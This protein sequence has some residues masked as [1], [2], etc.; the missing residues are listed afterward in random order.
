MMSI[1]NVYRRRL[2]PHLINFSM[3]RM[4]NAGERRG[5][6]KKAAGVVLEIGCGSGLNVPLYTNVTKLYALDPSRKL[7][8]LGHTRVK[9]APFPI[10]FI[11]ASAEKI[12]L[13]DGTVDTVVSTWTLCSIPN[14]ERALTEVRRVLK[15]GGRFL[16]LEHGA[17]SK[18]AVAKW[19]ERLTP[20]W[21]RI[22]GGCHL[23][24]KP[25]TLLAQARFTVPYVRTHPRGFFG[26]SHTYTGFAT[27]KKTG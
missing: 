13:T 19:Q 18:R 25:D 6:I 3:Q 17:S 21:S 2:L 27:K 24:R 9:A 12:P 5:V 8:E 7:W 16:F 14:P 10:E 20:V 22:A 11:E 1:T 26:L 4:N 23:D 15:P